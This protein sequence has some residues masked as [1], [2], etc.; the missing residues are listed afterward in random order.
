MYLHTLTVVFVSSNRIMI[1]T[2][3]YNCKNNHC[4][5]LEGKRVTK[6]K[7]VFI[8]IAT[9]F[10]ILGIITLGSNFI[11]EIMWFKSTGYLNVFLSSLSFRLIVRFVSIIVFFIFVY[12]N[13]VFAGR[14]L[15]SVLSFK[16]RAGLINDFLSKLMKG[17]SIKLFFLGISLVVAIIFTSFTS[18]YW[19]T[20]QRYL[21][22][23]KFDVV[24]P[25]FK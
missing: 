22:S 8:L 6:R 18:S 10:I 3:I 15:S 7:F 16:N 17:R 9:I 19:L 24:E 2:I 20:V 1:K 11:T 12:F 13:L 21:H 5:I 25:L 4:N 14:R 23:F